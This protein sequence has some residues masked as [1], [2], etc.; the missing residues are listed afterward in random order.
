MGDA[1]IRRVFQSPK[2]WPKPWPLLEKGQ[3]IRVGLGGRGTLG[4]V[5]AIAQAGDRVEYESSPEPVGYRQAWRGWHPGRR[6]RSVRR[7]GRVG[8][9]RY[10]TS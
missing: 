3:Q 4:K 7:T 2:N 1:E 5:T 6:R 10:G 8:R 9:C